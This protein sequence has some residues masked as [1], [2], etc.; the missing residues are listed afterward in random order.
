VSA[1]YTCTQCW[2]TRVKGGLEHVMHALA[3]FHMIGTRVPLG[4]ID[5]DLGGGCQHAPRH[6]ASLR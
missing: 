6:P 4:D 1:C 5:V 3:I 2:G